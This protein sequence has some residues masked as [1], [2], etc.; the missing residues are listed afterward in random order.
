MALCTYKNKRRGH[1]EILRFSENYD[2]Y[3]LENEEHW[4][5]NFILEPENEDIQLEVACINTPCRGQ[6]HSRH[7]IVFDKLF[8][9]ING[10]FG[11]RKRKHGKPL[12]GPAT[13]TSIHHKTWQECKVMMK[14]MTFINTKT[15]KDEN[16]PTL[17]NWVWTLEGCELLL[18]QFK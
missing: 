7:L 13:P 1:S 11:K 3:V 8:D 6:K 2:C 5:Q 10:S 4:P 12:L 15:S 14:D 9:S 18:K 17:N 16:V